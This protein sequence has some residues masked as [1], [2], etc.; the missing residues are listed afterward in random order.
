MGL[1]EDIERACDLLLKRQP[2]PPCGSKRRPHLYH[3]QAAGWTHCASCGD[4]I[5]VRK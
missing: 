4:S 5:F 3:P 2:L 1:R